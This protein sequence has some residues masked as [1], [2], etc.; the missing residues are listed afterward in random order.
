MCAG[1]LSLRS[2][3][4]LQSWGWAVVG[5]VGRLPGGHACGQ[6][7]MYV[8]MQFVGL[9]FFCFGDW[10]DASMIPRPCLCEPPPHGRACCHADLDGSGTGRG[11][12]TLVSSWPPW[13]STGPECSFNSVWNVHTCDLLPWRYP[14]RLDI[15]VP[16]TCLG[17]G[18]CGQI[19]KF[20]SL[21]VR[22]YEPH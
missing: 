4:F 19:T 6:V 12:P 21:K 14:A 10:M 3:F 8:Y 20:D 2:A 1:W 15:R 22:Y 7:V 11:V 16:G 17:A 9:P 5:R 18:Q 13:W